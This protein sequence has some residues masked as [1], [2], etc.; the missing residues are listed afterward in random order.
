MI[1]TEYKDNTMSKSRIMR[2]KDGLRIDKT[3]RWDHP[4]AWVTVAKR[5]IEKMAEEMLDAGA[6]EG[7]G[8]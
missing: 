8:Q 5:A 6:A 7:S 3:L 1:S 4:P 2:G